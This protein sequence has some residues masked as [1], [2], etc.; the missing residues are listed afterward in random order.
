MS[1]VGFA[2]DPPAIQAQTDSLIREEFA[3]DDTGMALQSARGAFLEV[4]AA[5]A[6]ERIRTAAKQLRDHAATLAVDSRDS[7]HEAAHDLDKLAV[8]V[9]ERGIQSVREFDNR[10]ARAFHTIAQHHV[11]SG[12]V[13]WQ[14]REYRLAGRRLRAAA[15]NLETA[16]RFS[17]QRVS[18]ATQ[19]TIR[20]SR[21]ISAKLIEGSGY[22]VDDVGRAFEGLGREVENLG[23][24]MQPPARRPRIDS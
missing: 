3:T 7:L 13:A 15:D 2:V 10:L 5:K 16:L 19:E 4:D 22:A 11:D 18:D 9:E 12:R 17:G 8:R 20:G 1:V 14:A 21:M 24:Q 23:A 6:G